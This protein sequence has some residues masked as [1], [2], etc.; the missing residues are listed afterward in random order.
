MTGPVVQRWQAASGLIWTHYE[1]SEDWVV[2]NPASGDLHLLTDSAQRLWTL[3]CAEP[4][5]SVRELAS[6]LAVE[7]ASLPND[8]LSEATHAM[9]VFMDRAGLV[10]PVS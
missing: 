3:A 10:H 2:Y 9:V 5:R 8:E 7:T 4:P 6:A 1:D